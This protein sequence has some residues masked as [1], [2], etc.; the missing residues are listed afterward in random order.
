MSHYAQSAHLGKLAIRIA[1]RAT[2]VIWV[3]MVT[4]LAHA[5]FVKLANIKTLEGCNRAP[6]ALLIP[7]LQTQAAPPEQIVPLAR[8]EQQRTE[9]L[10]TQTNQVA[11]ALRAISFILS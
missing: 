10:P 4:N 8:I 1:L 3:N 9:L 5:H 7:T 2:H 6:R 11:Y